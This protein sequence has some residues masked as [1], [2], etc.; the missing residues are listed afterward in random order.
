[1]D[2]AQILQRTRLAAGHLH[3]LAVG[4]DHV[5]RHAVGQRPVRAPVEQAL[6][7]GPLHLV[8]LVQQP[9]EGLLLRAA[10]LAAAL[11]V[12]GHCLCCPLQRPEFE[13]HRPVRP[14]AVLE[15]AR[16]VGQHLVVRD[17]GL[18]HL[19]GKQAQLRVEGNGQY[20]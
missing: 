3:G 19:V 1:M 18:Q 4:D 6:V 5:P 17:H 15:E 14:A 11:S 8:Q 13:H 2:R 12:P 20:S 9:A 7:A 10:L 16:L